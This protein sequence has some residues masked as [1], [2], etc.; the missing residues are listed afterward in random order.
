MA[1]TKIDPQL[2][3]LQEAGA[4]VPQDRMAMLRLG[5]ELAHVEP[6][7]PARGR[8]RAR[9]AA[10]PT[11]QVLVQYAGDPETLTEAGLHIRSING[12]VISGVVAVEDIGELSAI[13]EVERLEAARIMQPELDLSRVEC[14]ANLVHTGPPGRRGAGVIVGIVDGGIDIE[15]RC[16]RRPDGTSR[17]LSLWV[18]G[19]A[20][21]AGEASP[22]PFGYGV[23]Y[24]QAQINAALT[25]AN[26]FG[27]VRHQDTIGHG[28]HVAGIAAGDGSPFAPGQTPFTFV[29]IAPEADMIV[30]AAANNGTEGLGTSSNALDAVNYVFTRAGTLNRPAVVNMSLGDNLG[31]HDGTS[32][33]ERGLDNLLGAAGRAFVKSAGNAG[34]DD[35]HARGTVTTGATVDVTFN[36]PMGNNTL[37]QM[38]LWYRGTDTFRVSIVDPAG[39]VRGPVNVGSVQTLNFPGNNTVRVD[40]R[41][42]DPFNGDKRAFITIRP[43]G[44]ATIATGNWRLRLVSVASSGGGA[45]DV[46]IQRGPPIPRF[47]APHVDSSRTIST[48]GTAR[49][50]ITAA[51]YVTRGAGVG[52][53]ASSSS[54]GPT[55][56]GRSAPT[57][58][59]PGQ[60]IMSAA[61]HVP[62]GGNPYVGKFGTSMAAP[63]VAGT[64]ALMFQKNRNRTQDQIRQCLESTARSDAQTGPVPNTAWGA[65]KMD[66][67]AAVNC[68]PSPRPPLSTIVV[69][70][71]VVATCGTR[72]TVVVCGPSVVTVCQSVT[73]GCQPSVLIACVTRPPFCDPVPSVVVACNSTLRCPSAI[74]AC[75]SA[76][77]GC[78]PGRLVQPAGMVNPGVAVD[79]GVINP[80]VVMN[81]RALGGVVHSPGETEGMPMGVR[82]ELQPLAQAAQQPPVPASGYF[83]YDDGWFDQG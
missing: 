25:S 58:A 36:E 57:I 32:L 65:G 80:G 35:I 45:F 78:G 62:L 9:A 50:V 30:V 12:D 27:A 60:S 74:D 6:A 39:N 41:N 24:S 83:E 7:A 46:W 67:N 75:P 54:R 48:P 43:A 23:E 66:S 59:A 5:L 77:A 72:S 33:L 20:P 10:R 37:D 42:N 16:F 51:N 81:Q 76:P 15:H 44:A 53:I 8:R 73:I 79:P 17:I 63:H 22:A 69:C 34:A 55:R 52:S 26:P 13:A 31:P 56:D 70:Q 40:H 49:E 11:V 1:E 61:A 4:E 47:L 29:G 38:D 64:I 18:Q 21:Q 3:M 82:P 2:A 28:T 19:L 71:S 68:V 14:R